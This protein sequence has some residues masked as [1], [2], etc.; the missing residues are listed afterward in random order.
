VD[1]EWRDLLRQRLAQ[2][3]EGPLGRVVG[4]DAAER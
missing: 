4:A 3:F 1:A 2:P